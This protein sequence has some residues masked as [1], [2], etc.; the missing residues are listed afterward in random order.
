VSTL[1]TR[2]HFVKYTGAVGAIAGGGAAL[3]SGGS[4]PLGLSAALASANPD[5]A[6]V[7]AKNFGFIVL[8]TGGDDHDNLEWALRNTPAGGT[9]KLEEG[10]YKFGS[11]IVVPDFDGRLIGAGASKTTITCTD[12]YSL[13]VWEA[14][15]GPKDNGAPKPPPFPR[16]FYEGSTTRTPPLLIQ[17]YKTPLQPGESPASR[18]NSIEVKNL[19]CRGAMYGEPWM[20]GDEV[21][22]IN[23]LNTQDWNNP[24]VPQATT[25]QDVVISGVFVDGYHSTA[26]GPFENACACIT[27][28]GGV[29]LTANYDLNG[30]IDG[31]AF[32]VANGA[33]LDLT[34]AEGNVTFES[35]MFRNCRVGPGVI[36]YKNGDIKFTDVTTDGCRGNCLQMFDNN[37]MSIQVTRNNLFCDSFL[38]PPAFAGGATDV[39]S[40]Q[41]CVVAVQGIFAAIGLPYNVRWAELAFDPA[42]HI[43][44]P[45]AGPLGTWRPRGPG[46]ASMP[47]SLQ[48]TN[49]ACRSSQTDN[50]Y[51]FHVVDFM[52]LAFGIES[53]NTKISR[54]SCSDSKTCVSLE[55]V[56]SAI[57]VDNSCASREFGVELYNSADAVVS[58]NK[59][60]FPAGVMGCEIRELELGDKID[61]SRVAPGAGTCRSQ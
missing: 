4:G 15:G 14:P 29:V 59:F 35:C 40:S 42:A 33:M 37:A 61:L 47:S 49:N 38:L 25:R 2:R 24:E 51:C 48:I 11:P 56:N 28:A 57:V 32:G 43:A 53:I 45:E 21:L 18:A 22:C 9:V 34:R 55:H 1:S 36:G 50:T 7:I 31:D 6:H 52:K 5:P 8:P 12:E 19:R 26:F 23:I 41:G 3:S 54:N 20:F 17:F 46:I 10:V 39:P 13:E 60:D 27:I 58:R 16:R 30:E 44:H